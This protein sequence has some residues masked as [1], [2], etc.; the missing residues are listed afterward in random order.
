MIMVGLALGCADSGPISEKDNR[1]LRQQ[2]VEHLELDSWRE[3]IQPEFHILSNAPR[4]EVLR[5]ARRLGRFIDAAKQISNITRFEPALPMQIL[6]FRARGQ[7]HM[8]PVRDAAGYAIPGPRGIVL[9][10]E[11]ESRDTA[12]GVLYHEY[13]HYLFNNG[14]TH[15]YPLWYS[16]GVAEM[17]RTI[18]VRDDVATVGALPED[19]RGSLMQPEPT[20]LNLLLDA[21]NYSQL[22]D[23]HRFY[24]DSWL[25]VHYLHASR[26]AEMPGQLTQY[27]EALARAVPPIDAWQDAFGMTLDE[28][29]VALEKHRLR[30]LAPITG[31][32]DVVVPHVGRE[33]RIRPLSAQGMAV[34]LGEHA[35]R[36][37][38]IRSAGLLLR[39][40]AL[41]DPGDPLPGLG[42]AAVAMREKRWPTAEALALEA[43]RALPG[44]SLAHERL[45]DVYYTQMKSLLESGQEDGSHAG[46][47]EAAI[48]RLRQRA[49]AAYERS[50]AVG[51]DIWSTWYSLGLT[52]IEAGEEV[53]TGMDA[54]VRA[55]DLAPHEPGPR[56]ALA[57]MH[58]RRGDGEQA[59][60]LLKVVLQLAHADSH[61]EDAEELLGEIDGAA[62]SGT[63]ASP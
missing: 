40:A 53:A 35:L 11:L 6:L 20:P 32:M 7:F 26:G 4:S 18:V 24:A 12:M 9:A 56:L 62:G 31:F 19:R 17:F 10:S 38:Q 23:V 15:Y 47:G 29:E 45:G 44:E 27:L 33:I 48:D 3:C 51:P 54:L 14:T 13:T 36:V 57:R 58:L 52:Y 46:G 39:E 25:L 30:M 50:T 16:E 5:A 42:L 8:F 61:R 49:R 55:L 60:Q 2:I 34:T 37:G 43:V 1:V 63:E 28:L 59:R 22:E 21:T 41:L